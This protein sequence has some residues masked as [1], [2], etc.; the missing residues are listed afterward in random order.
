MSDFLHSITDQSG[1]IELI[2]ASILMV[3]AMGGFTVHSWLLAR[4]DQ[5]RL[6]AERRRYAR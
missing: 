2:G 5:K 1:L 4:A 3:V 6:E